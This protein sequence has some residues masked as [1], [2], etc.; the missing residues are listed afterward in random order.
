MAMPVL[1]WLRDGRLEAD[2]CATQPAEREPS[3]A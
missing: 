3:L 2:P 1:R